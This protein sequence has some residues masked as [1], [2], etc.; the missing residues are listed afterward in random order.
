MGLPRISEPEARVSIS[1]WN[2]S[3]INIK[4]IIII[5]YY[6]KKI[7][8]W[9]VWRVIPAKIELSNFS[10]VQPN[11]G[12]LIYQLCTKFYS[13]TLNSITLSHI[14]REQIR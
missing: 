14:L 1:V 13:V 2:P 5:Y 12:P 8:R 10:V 9:L 4:F 6:K 3:N 7:T 11:S